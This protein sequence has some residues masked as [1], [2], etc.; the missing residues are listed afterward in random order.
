VILELSSWQLEGLEKHRFS[1][2]ISVV[3]NIMEDHLNSYRG[4]SDYVRAKSLILAYQSADDFAVI[5]LDDPRV[6]AMGERNRPRGASFA[7][8]RFPFSMK[9]L[10]G[11]GCFVRAK[12]IVL[13]RQGKVSE[14]LPLSSL[15]LAGEH[16]VPNVLAACAAASVMGVPLKTMRSAVRQFRGIDGRLQ[17]VGVVRGVRYV[18]DTTA[19]MPDASI[20]A[21]K[22]FASGR[23]KR[24][25]LIA[26]GAKKGLQYKEWAAAVKKYA[27]T[28]ILLDG[29]ETPT[30]ERELQRAGYSGEVWLVDSMKKA[31][32]VAH[33]ISER[34]DVVLM[35]PACSSF[36]LFVN[37]FD[38]GDQFAK[39]VRRLK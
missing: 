5:N 20:A 34:G 31:V 11:D 13:R 16:N 29:T 26:G 32:M 23:T 36:G 3:T 19:T 9:A 38:R 21:L 1:P 22:A 10:R 37:E 2:H 24:T 25:V 8:R 27:K 4:M 30:L 14:V 15:R 35:S 33:N 12:K 17:E 28:V 7:G 39:A 18:N 6:A